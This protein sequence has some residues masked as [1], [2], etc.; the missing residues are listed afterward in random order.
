MKLEQAVDAVISPAQTELMEGILLCVGNILIINENYRSKLIEYRV[1]DKI[2]IAKFACF[3]SNAKICA[4]FLWM[5]TNFLEKRFVV[6]DSILFTMIEKAFAALTKYPTK[7]NIE[8]VL[9]IILFCLSRKAK[10]AEK[11]EFLAQL[12]GIKLCMHYFTENINYEVTNHIGVC[13]C[14]CKS[15]AEAGYFDDF[16]P[17]LAEVVFHHTS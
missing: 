10:T 3:S 4:H 11:V 9:F 5:I 1:L 8:E 7:Q 6:T 15:T 2:V 13:L 12:G 17:N 14:I 16:P